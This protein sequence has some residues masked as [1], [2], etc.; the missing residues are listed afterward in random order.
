MAVEASR[1]PAG[2]ERVQKAAW[3]QPSQWPWWLFAAIGLGL[4]LVVLVFT[5]EEARS[6][7]WYMLGQTPESL[8]A[9]QLLFKGIVITITIA[10]FGY[11]LAMVVGLILGLMRTSSNPILYNIASFYV[12]VIRGV[13][14]LVLLLYVAFVL[15]PPLTPIF[16]GIA[17]VFVTIGNVF[18]WFLQQLGLMVAPFT[19]VTNMASHWR[20]MI[21]LGLGYA[22]FEAEIFRAGIQS[23]ERG[24]HEAAGALGLNYFQTMRFII[25]PQAIRRVL[26]ALGNDFIAMVKDSSLASVLGVQDMTQL[27]KLV[28]AGN[29]LY[30]QTLTMLAFIYLIMVVLLTRLV[31]WMEHRLQRVYVR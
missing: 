31:R 21:A 27:A 4:Y 6:S 1:A 25:L 14:M 28:A 13:P 24:Q 22:A 5:D 11:A 9:G 29:F 19:P 18:V 3:Q 23:I 16:T 7:F 20:A 30:M 26:P 8:G 10:V 2:V 12:E 17:N 15:A